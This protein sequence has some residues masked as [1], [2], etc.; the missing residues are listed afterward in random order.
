LR[1]EDQTVRGATKMKHSKLVA[2]IYV[3]PLIHSNF[4]R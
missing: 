2:F 4:V 3:L 1:S